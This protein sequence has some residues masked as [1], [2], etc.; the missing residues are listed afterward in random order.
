LGNGDSET[1]E[2]NLSNCQIVSFSLQNDSIPG[3]SDV[4]FTIDQLN[5]LIFN[6]D[7]MLYGTQINWKVVCSATY[8]VTPSAIEVY[9]EATKDSAYWNS[10]DSLDFSDFVRFRV[11]SYDGKAY[12]AYTA[13]LNIHQQE[14][15]SMTWTLCAERLTGKNMQEQKVIAAN[16]FYWMYVKSADG[17]ELYK[18]PATDAENWTK[19]PLNGLSDKTFVLSQITEYEGVLYL[20]ASDGTCYASIDGVNWDIEKDT[21]DIRVL[22]GTVE[23][24]PQVKRP[25]ALAAVI[26]EG[27]VWRFAAMDADA[28]WKTGAAIPETFPVTGFGAASY[29]QMYYR[30]LI[31]VA[32]K[33]RNGGL[34]NTAWDTMDGL[35]WVRLTD[36][37]ASFFEAREGVMLTQ[38]DEK[39][40]LIG[41]IDASNRAIK[42]IYRSI[43]KGITWNLADTLIVLP[44]TYRA[45]GYASMLVDQDHFILLF[46]GKESKNAN[47][48][49]E[50]WRGR[51]NRLGFF[52]K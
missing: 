40:F 8:V 13:R 50:L 19:T 16:G 12:K 6:K 35:S 15:D 14:P 11:Y 24:S 49:D 3:L 5:G 47:V 45:R 18:S 20:P 41:G 21:P 48:L 43:D 26:R 42:D 1:D 38:Y 39:L 32:G 46:G 37:G 29:E 44:E 17:Y 25:S 2:W 22:L 4:K 10:S 31:V 27:D 34:S 7:S 36:E 28:H 33:D 23:A 30:H 52:D 9:Q 51:I